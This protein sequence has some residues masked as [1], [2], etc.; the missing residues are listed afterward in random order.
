MSIIHNFVD[1]TIINKFL[2]NHRNYK[3]IT[4]LLIFGLTVIFSAIYQDKDTEQ[5]TKKFALELLLTTVLTLAWLGWDIM[6][7]EKSLFA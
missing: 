1:I 5:G 7:Q 6:K 3:L 4:P 2:K